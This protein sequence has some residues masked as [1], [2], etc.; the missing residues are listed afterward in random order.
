MVLIL[1]GDAYGIVRSLEGFA[2]D[3]A[4]IRRIIVSP[5]ATVLASGTVHSLHHLESITLPESMI[6]IERTAISHFEALTSLYCPRS[7]RY[8]APDSIIGCPI[9]RSYTGDP[10]IPTKERAAEDRPFSVRFSVLHPAGCYILNAE[11]YPPASA[12]LSPQDLTGGRILHS[13]MRKELAADRI[14]GCSAINES[15]EKN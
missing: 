10:S 15:G 12:A 11:Q 8:I 3:P 14:R 9:V 7:I 5:G 1:R 6:E 4:S 2:G 13:I